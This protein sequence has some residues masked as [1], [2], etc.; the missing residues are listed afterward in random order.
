[1]VYVIEKLEKVFGILELLIQVM[2]NYIKILFRVTNS[3]S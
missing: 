3:T 1:M 2:Q